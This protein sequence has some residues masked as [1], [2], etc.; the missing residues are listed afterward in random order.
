[1]QLWEE[2]KIDLEADVTVYL[3]EGFF[4]KLKYDEPITMINLMN[5][6]AGFEDI[7]FEMCAENESSILSLEEALKLTEPNQIYKPGM[8]RVI[9][10]TLSQWKKAYFI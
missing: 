1:M 7:V 3:P 2:G 4:T 6:N 10:M 8:Q 9:H 5:H